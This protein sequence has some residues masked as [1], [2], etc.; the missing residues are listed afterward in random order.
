M[1]LALETLHLLLLF[2]KQT[3]KQTNTTENITSFAKDVME[4]INISTPPN[5]QNYLFQNEP[6]NLKWIP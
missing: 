1:E 3:D 6:H 4:L 5:N 2:I